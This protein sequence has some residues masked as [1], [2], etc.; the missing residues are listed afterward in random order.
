MR[1]VNPE[2]EDIVSYAN[3]FT[4]PTKGNELG[5]ALISQG[6]DIIGGA[7]GG[8]GVGVAQAAA[9]SGTYYVAWDVHYEAVVADL[10]PVSYTH[11]DAQIFHPACP[12]PQFR[13]CENRQSVCLPDFQGRPPFCRF[14]IGTIQRYAINRQKRFVES[15][16]L[17]SFFF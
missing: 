10:E 13:F 11:L 4:D 7:A 8:T 17:T 9:D 15:A 5:L 2:I 16:R 1:Y 6:C 3:T 12:Y 14:Q